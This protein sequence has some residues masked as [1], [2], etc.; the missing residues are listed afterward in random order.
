M[1]VRR[2]MIGASISGFLF[3]WS[4]LA[5]AR[6]DEAVLRSRI[7]KEFPDA[8]KALEEHFSRAVGSVN[9]SL[10]HQI[11]KPRQQEMV[12]KFTF[13]T[14]RPYWARV[15][16]SRTRPAG[17]DM[18]YCFNKDYSFA[19]VKKDGDAQYVIRSFDKNVNG[20]PPQQSTVQV[21]GWLY[22]Y[23]DAPFSLSAFYQPLSRIISS[24][25]FSIQR[26]F[27]KSARTARIA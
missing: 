15:T 2:A 1:R 23:L 25:R 18:V 5:C 17:Q 13:A 14:R 20:E 19:L 21:D 3:L 6:D 8:L 22:E 16:S 24:D 12:G 7:L 9:Y 27:P 26:P 4:T 11:G 10:K